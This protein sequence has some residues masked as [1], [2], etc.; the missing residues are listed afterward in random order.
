MDINLTEVK[1]VFLDLG[2][3]RELSI[4]YS[5]NVVK[6]S[7]DGS[8]MVVKPNSNNSI[9]LLLENQLNQ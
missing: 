6:L 9:D 5:D 7:L 2:N 1:R 8:E 3:N 4:I